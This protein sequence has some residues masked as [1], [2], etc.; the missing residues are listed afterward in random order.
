MFRF[1]ATKLASWSSDSGQNDEERRSCFLTCFQVE[2]KRKN[3][4]EFCLPEMNGKQ[5]NFERPWYP[6][7]VQVLAATK[8]LWSV[9]PL[10]CPTG[11]VFP[12]DYQ[13]EQNGIYFLGIEVKNTDEFLQINDGLKEFYPPSLLPVFLSHSLN[14]PP[15][16]PFFFLWFWLEKLSKRSRPLFRN[17]NIIQGNCVLFFSQK[18]P[19]E[20]TTIRSSRNVLPSVTPFVHGRALG[21]NSS[22][23]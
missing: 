5:C 1:S 4:E 12:S 10:F 2:P 11:R 13:L 6:E 3:Q 18:P 23:R 19:K 17:V 22:L 8:N 21:L 15:S 7:K 9:L 14:L 16:L 20:P